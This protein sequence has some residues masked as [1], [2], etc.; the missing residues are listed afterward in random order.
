MDILTSTSGYVASA[1]HNR[2]AKPYNTP[3]VKN[4]PQLTNSCLSTNIG[5]PNVGFRNPPQIFGPQGQLFYAG[6]KY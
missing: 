3:A 6:N 2:N 4:T 5:L 1:N